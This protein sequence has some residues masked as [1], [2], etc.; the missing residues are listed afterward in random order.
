MKKKLSRNVDTLNE[1]SDKEFSREIQL[2]ADGCDKF[3]MVGVIERTPEQIEYALSDLNFPKIPVQ[4]Y[5]NI[6]VSGMGGSAL[7][8]EVLV[9]AFYDRF[10]TTIDVCRNYRCR[11][12]IFSQTL[13]VASSFSGNTEETISAM[14]HIARFGAHILVITAG[15]R[16]EELAVEKNYP[17]VRIPYKREG[18]GFQSRSA[19]GYMVTYLARIL[20]AAGV[21]ED[22][23]A[24]LSTLPV[25]FRD[26]KIRNKA[27]ETARWFT[28]RIPVIYTDE[29][30]ERSIARIFKI[31]LNEN[32]KR[33]AF[34]YGLPE[35]N[36]N[37]MIGFSHQNNN[38]QY[39]VLY[40]KDPASEKNV[41]LRFETM[42]ELFKDHGI[43]H[44]DFREWTLSGSTN[45]EKI[46]AGLMFGDWCAYTAALLNH[47]DPSPVD[48]V[49]KF[50]TRLK[51]K[52]NRLDK[53]KI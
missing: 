20:T 1:K 41:H 10:R 2:L 28:G 52:Q 26:L 4:N 30:F 8:V 34:Y 47:R 38:E 15:G 25:F 23:A 48:L 50:K 17:L 7:P 32:A 5:T 14:E 51:E 13:T 49:E 45:L 31:K 40:L 53:P 6:I 36:H 35:A 16:L 29:S 3:D 24:E 22:P 39:A 37:E 11:T 21:L 43:N 12:K 33:P 27:E 9:D 42:K 19:T 18:E 46:F 44:V